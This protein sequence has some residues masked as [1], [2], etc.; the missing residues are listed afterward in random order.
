VSGGSPSANTPPDLNGLR[1][2]AV[3]I[4]RRGGGSRPDV[5]RVRLGDAEAVLKDQSAC[6]PL[7][8]RIVG[9]LLAGR[10]ARALRLLRGVDGVPEF[11]GRPDG[12]SLLMSYEPSTPLT[13]AGLRDWTAF[14]ESLERL[15]D[16]MHTRGVA[17]CDLRS[18]D[19]TLVRPDGAPVVVDFVASVRRGP[20]WNLPWRWVFRQLC[21]VDR[22]ALVKL[23]SI[24]APELLQPGDADQLG[25]RSRLHRLLRATGAAVRRVSRLL[26]TRGRP[27]G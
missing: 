1:A 27:G 2:G 20:A 22:K 17:H 12:R 26:F 23:K 21:R 7:F 9:P 13:R 4:M 11:L 24:A 8:A 14:F 16:A 15:L 19:N 3:E 5:L 18:P 10:E 25:H 6:D